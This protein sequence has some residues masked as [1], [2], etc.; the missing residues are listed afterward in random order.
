MAALYIKEIR[1][2]QS[3]GPYCLGGG[4]SG[5]IVAFEMAQQLQA[6]GQQVAL[7]ALFDPYQS[8]L[9]TFLRN[10]RSLPNPAAFRSKTNTL[11]QRVDLHLGQLLLYGPKDYLV[12]RVAKLKTRIGRKLQEITYKGSSSSDGALSRTLQVVLEANRQALSA[13]LP[14]VYPGRL[15]L[16]LCSDAPERSFFDSRWGWSEMAAEGLEVHVI[17]GS[18]ETMFSEPHVRVV[19]E[20]LRVCL[21]KVRRRV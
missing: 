20:K 7:L 16:F 11:V 8:S 2:V 9:T 18:H 1:T 21:Q 12:G 15:T 13:Y 19:A 6:Q 10:R 17:P 4:S 3:E 5:G 14:Q